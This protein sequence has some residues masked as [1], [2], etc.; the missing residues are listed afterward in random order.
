MPTARLLTVCAWTSLNISREG[1]LCTVRSKWNKIDYVQEGRGYG[2]YMGE[3]R[4]GTL[5][6]ESLPV[7]RMTDT[8]N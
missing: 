8:H 1:G 7:D 3:A 2:L 5:C 6:R 4:A